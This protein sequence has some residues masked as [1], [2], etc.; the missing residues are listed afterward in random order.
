MSEELAKDALI[1]DLD[2][3]FLKD[4]KITIT[5]QK[6]DGTE[7]E[8]EETIKATFKGS[9]RACALKYAERMELVKLSAALVHSEES[10]IDRTRAAI[11]QSIHVWERVKGRIVAIDLTHI[12]SGD[13]LNSLKDIEYSEY[14]AAVIR[15]INDAFQK[16]LRI[17]KNSNP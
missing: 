13:N 14:G 9:V 15:T 16:G 6:A 11:D 17:S 10:A 8:D 7:Y 5:K 4:R 12:E 3:A 2:L 1:V